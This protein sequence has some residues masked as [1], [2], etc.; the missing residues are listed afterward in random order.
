MSLETARAFFLWCSVINYGLLIVWALVATLGRGWH[1]GFAS[2]IFPIT[3]EQ[4]DVMNVCG[5]ALY[6]VGIFLFNI[7]P[8]ISLYIIK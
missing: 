2:R 4:Y 6:K 3:R 1:F 7:V 5:I 8:L